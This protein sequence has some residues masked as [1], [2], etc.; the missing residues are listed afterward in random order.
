MSKHG[1]CPS[2][3]K[4]QYGKGRR[5]K[6]GVMPAGVMVPGAFQIK[7]GLEPAFYGGWRTPADKANR[8]LKNRRARKST[9]SSVVSVQSELKEEKEAKKLEIKKMEKE[10]DKETRQM[11]KRFLR[12]IHELWKQQEEQLRSL[13]N[14]V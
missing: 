13:K 9:R 8:R 11:Q 14:S 10:H 12:K 7:N 2:S 1:F 4:R 5:V 6:R 3:K